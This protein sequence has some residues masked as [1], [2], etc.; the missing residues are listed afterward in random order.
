MCHAH[1]NAHTSAVSRD[2]S[3]QKMHRQTLSWQI[4]CQVRARST[5]V[6]RADLWCFSWVQ[7]SGCPFSLCRMWDVYSKPCAF[8]FPFIFTLLPE[9]FLSE[10]R[11]RRP[12][13]L[14]ANP[15]SLIAFIWGLVIVKFN[16]HWGVLY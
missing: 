3:K 12:Q 6:P 11:K 5:G 9:C 4:F 2:L 14:S 10:T 15:C 8:Y 7:P 13:E 16:R 1:L